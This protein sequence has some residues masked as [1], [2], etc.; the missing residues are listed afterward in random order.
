MMASFDTDAFRGT[1]QFSVSQS[2]VVS[3]WSEKVHAVS[4][5]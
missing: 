5:E 2:Y 4:V 3:L 1:D